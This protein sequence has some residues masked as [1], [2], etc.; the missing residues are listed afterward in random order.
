MKPYYHDEKAGITIYHA[1]CRDVLPTLEAGSVDLVLTDPPYG[2]GYLSSHRTIRTEVAKLLAND[3]SLEALREALRFVPRLLR[4]NCHVYYFASA[5]ETIGQACAV[6][7]DELKF[8][9][10]LCWDKGNWGM[11]DLDANY[12]Q[13]WEA[14]VF[15]S[16]GRRLLNG[17][18]PSS[19]LQTFGRGAGS[20]WDHP[21]QKPITLCRFL[22]QTSSNKGDTVLDP[23]MGSGTTL[24]AA[25]DLGRK[26]IGIEVEERYC[27]IAVKRLA[28]EVMAL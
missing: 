19:L 5:D 14:I 12:G 27:E 7:P 3:D 23:F 16:N 4:P 2:I 11:G 28:Q 9:R 22:I 26:A 1:D 6:L 21:T 25:K 13:Q 20:T 18:R 17:P 15:A 8:Q 24:R 10:L